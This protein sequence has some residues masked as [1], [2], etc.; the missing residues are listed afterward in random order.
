[1][2]KVDHRNALAHTDALLA[3]FS[4]VP[5]SA[6]AVEDSSG[7]DHKLVTV[8]NKSRVTIVAFND[9]LIKTENP[10]RSPEELKQLEEEAFKNI[11]KLSAR[12]RSHEAGSRL[13][14]G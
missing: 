3:S 11:Q 8:S 7:H 13:R 4:A 14:L 2:T 9:D 10:G 5:A 6:E 12:L 1:M